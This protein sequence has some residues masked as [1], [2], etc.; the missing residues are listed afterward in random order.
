MSTYYYIYTEVNINGKWIC[1]DGMVPEIKRNSSNSIFNENKIEYKIEET[2]WNGSRSYFGEAYD[3]LYLWGKQIG[4]KNLSQEL[5]DRWKSRL[6][7][8]LEKK[9]CEP[10]LVVNYKYIDK[11]IDYSK[12]DFHC[13]MHKDRIFKFESG[14]IE[15]M[16]PQEN[17]FSKVSDIEKQEYQYYEWD[18]PMGWNH[19]LKDVKRCVEHEISRFRSRND[20]WDDTFEYRVVII[21]C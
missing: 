10:A 7:S 16:W 9:Y 6:E 21:T 13:V 18:D 15:E 4:F 11:N 8:E 1:I 20:I 14:D 3:K 19:A 2:Y 12:F 5:K 17:D